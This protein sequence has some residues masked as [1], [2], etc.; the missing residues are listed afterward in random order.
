VKVIVATSANLCIT[1]NIDILQ[2]KYTLIIVWN[3][4]S[5]IDNETS[6]HITT[7]TRNRPQ[8]YSDGEVG[9]GGGRSVNLCLS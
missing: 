4:A 8:N 1:S 9:G 7:I 3:I 5:V 6:V 2:H